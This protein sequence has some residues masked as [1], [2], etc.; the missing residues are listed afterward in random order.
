[1]AIKLKA[2]LG[3]GPA[4]YALSVESKDRGVAEALKAVKAGVDQGRPLADCMRDQDVFDEVLIRL[5]GSGEARGHLLPEVQRAAGYLTTTAR[6]DELSRSSGP[7][8]LKLGGIALLAYL[9]VVA[10]ATPWVERALRAVGH[11]QW[12]AL[13]QGA[14]RAAGGI[15]AALPFV[16]GGLFLVAGLH[17]WGRR[18][19]KV[20]LW[21][22]KLLLGLP[23]VGAICRARAVADFG[24]AAG[25]LLS[26]GLPAMEAMKVA[27]RSSR[28]RV[29]RGAVLYEA[30][31]LPQARE[32]AGVLVEGGLVPRSELNALRAAER[33]GD[34]GPALSKLA[35]EHDAELQA[36]LLRLKSLVQSMTILALGVLIVVGMLALYVPTFIEH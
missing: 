26:T 17:F 9:V 12:S 19:R 18:R 7:Q 16:L 15:R 31:K 5:V 21:W 8:T 14:I 33:R 30:D 25:V 36:R 20:V 22:D 11:T 35:A 23:V 3:L 32:V 28:N 27:A 6:L 4:L 1:L 2:G 10:L 29:V 34:L 13:T 24:R